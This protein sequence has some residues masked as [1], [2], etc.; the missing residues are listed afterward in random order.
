MR[1]LFTVWL[2]FV[3]SAFGLMARSDTPYDP[4][5]IDKY[6]PEQRDL[7]V[8]DAKRS[9]EIPIRVYLPR[10]KTP[11]PI[12]LFSH[13]L[14][15]S[16]EGSAYLGNHWAARGY[17]AVFLQHPGSDD[18]VWKNKPPADRLAAMKAAVD[19]EN[20]VLRVD[21][22]R[23]IRPFL[24]KPLARN[25]YHSIHFAYDYVNTSGD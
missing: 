17:V 1:M 9:R 6:Q 24:S 23:A 15:G 19:L 3:F 4:L 7:T 2:L 21:D 22:V 5:L 20:F 25:W 10:E 16:R 18:S 11:A 12:V 8:K 13:G 14:G